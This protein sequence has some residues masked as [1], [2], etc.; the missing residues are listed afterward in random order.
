MSVKPVRITLLL[1]FAGTVVAAGL[2]LA[3]DRNALWTIAHDK[4]VPDEVKNHNPAP[5][6]LVNLTGGEAEGYAILKDLRGATQFLLIPTRK[7][8]GLESP[9]ILAPDLPNYWLDA[10][11]NRAFVAARAGHDLAFDMI[12][13]AV[14]SAQAR[15]QDQLH[16][17]MDCVRPDVRALLHAH[18]TEFGPAWRELSVPL[19]GQSYFARRLTAT[20]LAS[21]DPFKLFFDS[22]YEARESASEDTLA[23]IGA[24]FPSGQK[25]FVFLAARGNP[26]KGVRGHAEDL[27][28]HDCT[29]AEMK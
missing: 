11:E 6:V 29:V 12:G 28:D 7:I 3:Q 10:W 8:S 24:I 27:L 21:Q 17:H 13:L 18:I 22:V 5:C 1:L 4:C 15:S 14:N 19:A 20:D 16:I 9:D 26:D 23:L 2:A 25:D